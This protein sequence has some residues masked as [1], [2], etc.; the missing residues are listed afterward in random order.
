MTGFLEDPRL[1]K[2]VL[3]FIC[4]A[5][6]MSLFSST[7]YYRLYTIAK[8]KRTVARR[9]SSRNR[10]PYVTSMSNLS[11]DVAALSK[12]EI[13]DQQA[14]CVTEFVATICHT[15]AKENTTAFIITYVSEE[16]TYFFRCAI[17]LTRKCS[18]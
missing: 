10:I 18:L 4:A 9:R 15:A 14:L 11:Q 17:W 7:L 13:C 5:Y 6:H 1:H 16:K 3:L 12:K 8:S 2:R